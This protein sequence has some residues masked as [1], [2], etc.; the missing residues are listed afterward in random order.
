MADFRDMYGNFLFLGLFI[1]AG[2]SFMVLVQDQN[3]APQPIVDN[4]IFNRSFSNLSSSLESLEGIS[5]EQYDQFSGETPKTGFGSIVLFGIVSVG[6]TFMDVTMGTLLI[7][8]TLPVLVLGL[9]VTLV[10]VIITWTIISLIISV[11]ILYK[12]GG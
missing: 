1:F 10:S 12:L 2:I 11:W 5:G 9:P 7:I 3:D 6:K 8:V 4:V